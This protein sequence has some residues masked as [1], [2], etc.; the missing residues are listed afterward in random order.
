MGRVWE[1][2]WLESEVRLGPQRARPRARF[3]ALLPADISIPVWAER[4]LEHL[5][6]HVHLYPSLC[7]LP[8]VGGKETTCLQLSTCLE[9]N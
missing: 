1:Q 4:G 9:R 8:A 7:K 5:H 6:T 2:P 3:G